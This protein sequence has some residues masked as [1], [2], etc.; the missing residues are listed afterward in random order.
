MTVHTTTDKMFTATQ[1]REAR[2]IIDAIQNANYY[3]EN[4]EFVNEDGI[5]LLQVITDYGDKVNCND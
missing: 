3:V 5:K 2:E 4:A 1:V